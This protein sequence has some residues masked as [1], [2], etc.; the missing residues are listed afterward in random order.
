MK[1]INNKKKNWKL[2]QWKEREREI[3]RTEDQISEKKKEL[4]TKP[5]K[6]KKRKEEEDQTQEKKKR[7]KGKK[8]RLWSL[9]VCLITKMPLSYELLKLK[10][11][12]MCF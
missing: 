2:N 3:G 1:K 9:H 6:K 8:L 7:V 10:T 12:K 4:K 11:A 5:V